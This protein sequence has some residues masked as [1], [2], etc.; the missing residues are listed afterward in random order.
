MMWPTQSVPALVDTA[1][2]NGE[3]IDSTVLA[4]CRARYLATSVRKTMRNSSDNPSGLCNVVKVPP[5]TL[6]PP[7]AELSTGEVF[8]D[9]EQ[10]EQHDRPNERGTSRSHIPRPGEQP[11]VASRNHNAFEA[12]GIADVGS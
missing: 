12:N 3:Q 6:G 1:N 11:D 2:W 9:R 7:W 8:A 5:S 4:N 10:L